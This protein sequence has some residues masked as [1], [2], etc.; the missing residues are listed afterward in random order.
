MLYSHDAP[1]YW[2]W[3]LELDIRLLFTCHQVVTLQ[4]FCK[5]QRSLVMTFFIQGNLRHSTLQLNTAQN[6]TFLWTF[7]P[8]HEEDFRYW[9]ITH[10]LVYTA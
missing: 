7:F 5:R 9:P 8:L 6:Q 10:S 4:S 1:S 3:W 2:L